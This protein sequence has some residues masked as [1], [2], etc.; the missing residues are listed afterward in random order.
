MDSK[1]DALTVQNRRAQKRRKIFVG[2]IVTTRKGTPHWEC[3]I[4]NISERGALIRLGLD[5]MIPEECVLIN[6]KSEDVRCARVR[7]VRYPMCGLE[8]EDSVDA[9]DDDESVFVL[10]KKL[11]KAK[12][13]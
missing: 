12:R 9:G 6:L 11:I 8:F 7:W 1:D 13:G 4:R 10:A 5:Q 2:G 3:T